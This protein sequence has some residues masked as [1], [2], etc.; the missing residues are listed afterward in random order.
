MDSVNAFAVALAKTSPLLV[1]E[2]AELRTLFDFASALGGRRQKYISAKS[3]VLFL[4][5]C[6]FPGVELDDN[7]GVVINGKSNLL[8]SEV[9]FL[10]VAAEL[11]RAESEALL[12]KGYYDLDADGVA[13]LKAARLFR[14]M[15]TR[16]ENCITAGQ[17]QLGLRRLGVLGVVD[18]GAAAA[19]CDALADRKR[20][21]EFDDSS[22]RAEEHLLTID[23]FVAFAAPLILPTIQIAR[24]GGYGS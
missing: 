5:R 9:E 4:R 8:V 17:A 12:K 24:S 6:G 7:G 19:W 16:Y 21:L 11:A 1:D 15:D 22:V 23:E 3:C 18:A 13:R 10:L 20:L 14:S 2:I